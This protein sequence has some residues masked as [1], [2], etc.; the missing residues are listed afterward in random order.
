MINFSF[1]TCKFPLPMFKDNQISDIEGLQNV[2]HLVELR[3]A[4]NN[5]TKIQNLD[6]LHLKLLD[7]VS[8]DPA[9]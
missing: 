4:H 3:M 1:I 5:V 2:H 8:L 6:H 7:L 9:I